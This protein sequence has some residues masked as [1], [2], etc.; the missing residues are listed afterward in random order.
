[1][2]RVE[3]PENTKAR[4]RTAVPVVAATAIQ[5]E[6]VNFGVRLAGSEV[7]EVETSRRSLPDV[8]TRSTAE[9]TRLSD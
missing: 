4:T 1:M 7:A 8:S 6:R 9:Q 3:S 2:S 5:P